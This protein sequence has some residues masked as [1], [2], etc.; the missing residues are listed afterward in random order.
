MPSCALQGNLEYT[1]IRAGEHVYNIHIHICMYI[2]KLTLQVLFTLDKLPYRELEANNRSDF[3]SKKYRIGFCSA[4]IQQKFYQLL[5]HPCPKWV[6]LSFT[7]LAIAN[8]LIV[9]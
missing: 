7:C 1:S 4:D 9:I 8:F 3:Y 2:S 5:D 6:H